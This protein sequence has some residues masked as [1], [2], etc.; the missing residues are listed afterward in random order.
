MVFNLSISTH[1][2][3]GGTVNALCYKLKFAHK[4]EFVCKQQTNSTTDTEFGASVL[5]V[6]HVQGNTGL[7][8]AVTELA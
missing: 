3:Q 8:Q 6:L 4:D 5:P 2:N 1:H 7:S